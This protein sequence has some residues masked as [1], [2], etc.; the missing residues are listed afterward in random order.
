MSRIHNVRFTVVFHGQIET[1]TDEDGEAK[2][3]KVTLADAYKC[4]RARNVNTIAAAGRTHYQTGQDVRQIFIAAGITPEEVPTPTKSY[5]QIVKD[6]AER[7]RREEELE[8]GLWGQLPPE[9]KGNL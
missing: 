4:M 8:Q 9:E 7:I 2:L 5:R 3:V 6:E 1:E